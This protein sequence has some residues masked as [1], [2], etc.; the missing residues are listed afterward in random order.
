MNKFLL[1]KILFATFSLTTV[2]LFLLLHSGIFID[3]VGSI[4]AAVTI[5]IINVVLLIAS[6]LAYIWQRVNQGTPERQ[7]AT[8]LEAFAEDAQ[9][10]AERE[11]RRFFVN[12]TEL[13]T[14]LSSEG[15]ISLER[16]AK[17]STIRIGQTLRIVSSTELSIPLYARVL[18]RKGNSIQL[19]ILSKNDES[20]PS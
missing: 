19:E 12:D 20:S 15:K 16:D 4:E 14:L 11:P 5:Y 1:A 8:I 6:L 18:A 9:K 3:L 2:I 7:R 10:N 17:Y 13:A